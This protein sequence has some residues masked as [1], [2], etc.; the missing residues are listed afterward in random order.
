M[1]TAQRYADLIDRVGE[2]LGAS[3]WLTID[4]ALINGFAAV[5]G[6]H[7]W[8]HVDEERASRELPGGCTRSSQVIG[9]DCTP[10]LLPPRRTAQRPSIGSI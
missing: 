8:V 4:Q 9:F 7:M 5:T 1:I 6:D 10:S 2:E 3:T